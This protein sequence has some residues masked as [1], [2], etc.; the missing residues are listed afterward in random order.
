MNTQLK[1]GLFVLI[2]SGIFA[3][4]TIAFNDRGFGQDTQDYYIY[5]NM[6]EGLSKGAD[7]Q[8]KRC[9]GR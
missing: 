5:F 1:V 7:V 6:V 3:Y 2:I 4:L 9:K 8:V